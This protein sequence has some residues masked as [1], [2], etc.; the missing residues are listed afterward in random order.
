MNYLKLI[1]LS[2]GVLLL[3]SCNQ[4]TTTK[5][6]EMKAQK[7]KAL[8]QADMNLA[9]NPGDNFFEYANGGWMKA[10]PVP[11]DKTQ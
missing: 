7:T 11:S 9:V 2:L 6:S 5:D 8:D 10:H 3:A 4:S 1:P